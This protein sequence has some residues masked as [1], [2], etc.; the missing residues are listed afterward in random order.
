MP[1]PCYLAMTAAEFLQADPLP[2]KIAWMACHY[3]CYGAGLSNLPQTLPERSLIILNDR[4]P[5]CGHDAGLIADQLLQLWEET[6][7]FGFLLDLQRPDMATNF[8]VAHAVTEALPCPVAVSDVYGKEL[9]APIFL[10]LPPLDMPLEQYIAPWSG[11][12][13]WLEAGLQTEVFTVTEEGCT[14][15]PGLSRQLQEPVFEEPSLFIRYQFALTQQE[16]RFTLQRTK[17]ELDALLQSAEG[18][19]LAVGLYQQLGSA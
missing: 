10:P 2:E 8:E 14:V 19:T 7:P 17:K 18:V 3:A 13:I 11:R 15:V 16:A 5:P 12:E 4:T 6:K 1:I 9:A